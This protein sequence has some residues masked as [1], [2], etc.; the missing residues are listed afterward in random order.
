MSPAAAL[1]LV[2]LGLLALVYVIAVVA[3]IGWEDGA[4]AH[5][6]INCRTTDSADEPAADSTDDDA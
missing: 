5:A 2:L 1:L 3:R 4:T 6:W